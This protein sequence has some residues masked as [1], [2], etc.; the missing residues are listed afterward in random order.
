MTMHLPHSHQL[1][2]VP[3]RE[4]QRSDF[5]NVVARPGGGT[6]Y[7][8]LVLRTPQGVGMGALFLFREAASRRPA[9]CPA[10]ATESPW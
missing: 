3:A 7:L 6:E 5:Y 4:F 2:K 10:H 8:K 1:I 9:R